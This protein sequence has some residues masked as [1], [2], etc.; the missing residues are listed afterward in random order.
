MGKR[1]C[2]AMSFAEPR[3]Q[4][5]HAP[6]LLQVHLTVPPAPG[7]GWGEHAT[8]ATHITEGCLTGAMRTAT[9]H[10][11]NTRDGASS[12]PRLCCGLFTGNLVHGV[13]L[14]MVLSHVRVNRAD[15]IRTH[16]AS[17]HIWCF[18]L[19]RSGVAIGT[20]NSKQRTG[21]HCE[22]LGSRCPV[23]AKRPVMA[24]VLV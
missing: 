23:R 24:G 11:G 2:A 16:R 22:R 9:R 19:G 18:D 1:M 6:L 4:R 3:V 21:G 5:R 20:L 15:Q 14:A 8:S 13:W 17:K 7:L 12:T 10:T